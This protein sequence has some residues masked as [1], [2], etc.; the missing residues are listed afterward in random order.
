MLPKEIIHYRISKISLDRL[1]K[2]E[3]SALHQRHLLSV[4]SYV[5][6]CFVSIHMWTWFV[7]SCRFRDGSFS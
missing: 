4:S 1:P 5:S 6:Y 2:F 7:D 3:K